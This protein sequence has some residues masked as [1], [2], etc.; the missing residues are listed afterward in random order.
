MCW[1]LFTDALRNNWKG[2]VTDSI[3]QVGEETH[4]RTK[5][6][7]SESQQIAESRLEPGSVSKDCPYQPC[8]ALLR[9][10]QGHRLNE[11]QW[12]PL[13]GYNLGHSLTLSNEQQCTQSWWYRPTGSIK[14]VKVRMTRWGSCPIPQSLTDNWGQGWM[15][16]VNSY[17]WQRWQEDDTAGS[18]REWLE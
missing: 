12:P 15:R 7:F 2:T 6:T 9:Q 1:E 3:L 11:V 16:P 5:V 17:R 14:S 18:R 4:L 13:G 10:W 8:P